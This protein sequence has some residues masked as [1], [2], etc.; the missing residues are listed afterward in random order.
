MPIDFD[1]LEVL[2]SYS[3]SRTGTK[4]NRN[5]IQR[6]VRGIRTQNA[7]KKEDMMSRRFSDLEVHSRSDFWWQDLPIIGRVPGSENVAEVLLARDP[8]A[9]VTEYV[10]SKN[11]KEG[12]D[13]GSGVQKLT[14]V[15]YNLHP[16]ALEAYKKRSDDDGEGQ[17]DFW[18]EKGYISLSLYGTQVGIVIV[19]DNPETVQDLLVGFDEFLT[20]APPVGSVY[21][22]TSS[23]SGPKFHAIGKGGHAL[24]RQNYSPEVL[25]GYERIRTELTALNPR[26]RLTVVDGCPGSGKTFLV[27]GLLQE[28]EKVVFVV[29]APHF[30]A[31]LADPT[32]LTALV[33]LR[34]EHQDRPIIFIVEDADEVLAPRD[35]GNMSSISAVLN[36]GDGIMGSVL[37]VRVVATTNAE[38]QEL[39]PAVKRPGR[40][41]TALHV[42]PLSSEQ[43]N[44]RFEE[45]TGN[46]G[47]FKTSRGVVLAEVYQKAHDSGW[48]SADTKVAKKLGFGHD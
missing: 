14:E 41:S 40:L 29:V 16:D 6:M 30:L 11:F 27:R 37:D 1:D 9:T 10:S 22:M 18:F 35:A 23:P 8:T 19:A 13:D 43:A 44:S 15:I 38:R 34:A 28:V 45:L 5:S 48:K 3:V 2:T 32:A 4:I 42:G 39:D 46:P 12:L 36:L 17:I 25:E 24:E 7:L 33:K 21:M 20:D 47:D 31:A 26:G